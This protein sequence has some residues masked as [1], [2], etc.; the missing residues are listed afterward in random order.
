MKNDLI[1]HIGIPKLKK[2]LS[3]QGE[4][5][6]VV[7]CLCFLSLLLMFLI[8]FRIFQWLTA[9]MCLFFPT[10]R[11]SYDNTC[12]CGFWTLCLYILELNGVQVIITGDELELDNSLVISNHAS[13]VDYLIFPF[14]TLKSIEHQ[15]PDNKPTEDKIDKKEKKDKYTKL[16][17]LRERIICKDLTSNLLIP[18][19]NF[20]TWFH[21]WNMPSL[22]LFKNISE[23]DENWELDSNT[24]HSIFK[25]YLDD[26]DAS[27]S[28][29]WL[30]SFPE[31]NIFTEADLKIQSELSDKIIQIKFHQVI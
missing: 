16:M 6:R 20:F 5:L 25:N 29:S 13:L 3:T 12:A 30:V 24:L 9:M 22:K 26:S 14:L 27:E 7:R 19:M 4:T 1:R 31:V 21:I 10:A 17:D 23:T 28:P 15:F 8:T 2:L 11:I 18:K